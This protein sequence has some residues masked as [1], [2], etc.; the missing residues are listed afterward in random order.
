VKRQ[1]IKWSV[2]VV[3]IC[4]VAFG[5]YVLGSLN[6]AVH[7]STGTAFSNWG[8]QSVGGSVISGE[9]SV[10]ADGWAYGIEGGVSWWKDAGGTW[11]DGTWPSCLSPNGYHQIRFGWV[12]VT[13]P[14]GLGSRD[15]VW[16]ECP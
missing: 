7:V 2:L 5:A 11:H 4:A 9:A 10:K 3:V 15:V 13:T 14:S 16:V 12:Y 6:P 8:N 1:L